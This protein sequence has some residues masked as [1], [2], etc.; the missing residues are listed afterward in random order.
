MTDAAR[1][2]VHDYVRAGVVRGRSGLR[3][4]PAVRVALEAGSVAAHGLIDE[5]FDRLD[6]FLHPS[7]KGNDMNWAVL[8]P[9][10]L[11]LVRKLLEKKQQGPAPVATA[12]VQPMMADGDCEAFAV[13]ID[14][15][16]GPAAMAATADPVKFGDGGLVAVLQQ[17][18]AALRAKDW[19]GIKQAL[20]DIISRL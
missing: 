5:G 16:V 6:A 12:G 18:S 13:R 7:R 1:D 19:A 11:D 3:F 2:W 14:Q 15:L 8:I 20:A 9:I 10:I 17:L 4:R